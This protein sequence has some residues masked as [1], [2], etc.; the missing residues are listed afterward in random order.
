MT[1]NPNLHHRRSIRLNGYD[2]TLDG[3]YF[4]TICTMNRD[5]LFGE[6]VDGEIRLNELGLIVNNVW[7]SI[8]NH[9]F[10]VSLTQS[11]DST[12]VEPKGKKASWAS[13]KL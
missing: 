12:I 1:F 9:F 8:P 3:A 7:N 5:C 13:L 4:V 10:N 6:I 11:R 2:Y